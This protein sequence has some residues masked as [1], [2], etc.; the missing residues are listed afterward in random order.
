MRALK[1]LAVAVVGAFI[2]LTRSVDTA[3]FL[4]THAPAAFSDIGGIEPLGALNP[5]DNHVLAVDHMYLQYPTPPGDPLTSYPVSVM[6]SGSIVMVTRERFD[7][8]ADYDYGVFI[9]HT[10]SITSYVLHLHVPNANLDGILN[11]ADPSA[12]IAVG[13]LQVML[14]GQLGA[15]APIPMSGGDFLGFTKNYS[16]AWDVGVI[17]TKVRGDFLGRGERRYPKI[18]DYMDLLGIVA[19][20][21]FAGQ[22][23]LNARC[24]LD[25]LPPGLRAMYE[26][27]LT[28]PNCGRAGWDV[29]GRLRGAWFNRSIDDEP[30]P[31][32]RDLESGALSIIP[33]NR[34]PFTYVR[35]AFGAGSRFSAFD[36]D[37]D[38]PIG[39][40]RNAFR[41]EIDRTPDTRI[42]ADPIEVRASGG[43]YCYDLPYHAPEG[44]RFNSVRF[45]VEGRQLRVKYD[46]TPFEAPQCALLPPE[47]PDDSWATYVR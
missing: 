43:T 4:F 44:P 17:D 27:L 35:L 11:S 18:Q 39:Q 13:S 41:V 37:P 5:G 28:G 46:P 36:P 7:G 31:P 23:T 12:W 1:L 25:Y 15:P 26:R 22:Q 42:N 47:L 2:G 30:V 29:T 33:D 6:G 9:Q 19:E 3:G 45:L 21:P 14:L 10:R 20:P 40:L 16:H 38:R 24:F 32:L 8:R 34:E